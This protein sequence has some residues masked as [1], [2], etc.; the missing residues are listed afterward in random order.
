LNVAYNILVPAAPILV[1]PATGIILKEYAPNL[2]WKDQSPLPDHYQVQIATTNTFLP[3]SLVQDQT[4]TGSLFPANLLA[5]KI[6]YW[7]VRAFNGL[8]Q[9][10][11]WSLVRSIRTGWLPPAL[12]EPVHEQALQNK[13]PAFSWVSVSGAGSYNL[14]VSKYGTF[15]SP[16]INVNVKGTTYI[17]SIDLGANT[18]YYWRMRTNGVNGPSG[19]SEVRTFTTAN[20]PGTPLASLPAANALN[21]DYLP[22]FKWSA[23]SSPLGT[24]FDHYQIQVDDDSTFSST[25]IDTNATSPQYQAVTK[26]APNLKYYWRV[27]SFNSLGH[28]SAWSALRYFRT[29]MT[30]PVLNN[31]GNEST[32]SSLKPVFD[33]EDVT[34]AATYTIQV[35]LS[36]AFSTLLI[37]TSVKSSTYPSSVTLSSKKIVYWR[38]RANGLNGPTMWTT[39]S[40]TTP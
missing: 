33:W 38:V 10:G 21:T 2:D 29:V 9:A 18:L 8:G 34:G 23:V 24:D 11:P 19:W 25:A 14:Q 26:L 3:V 32:V 5:G 7:R 16:A 13:R 22:L 12:I 37:N 15:A 39:F 35:S 40:F 31:P 27:R 4:T 1:S 30:A 36:P 20:P 17:P 6:Y 28:Y